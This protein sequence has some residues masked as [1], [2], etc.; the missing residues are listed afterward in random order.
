LN[1][2][3]FLLVKIGQAW[4]HFVSRFVDNFGIPDALWNLI[5]LETRLDLVD[6]KAWLA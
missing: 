5:L 6:F 4:C 1:I 2:A 3:D